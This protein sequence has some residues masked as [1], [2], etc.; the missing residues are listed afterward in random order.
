MYDFFSKLYPVNSIVQV[1]KVLSELKCLKTFIH[2]FHLKIIIL[3]LICAIR[4][5]LFFDWSIAAVSIVKVKPIL[6]I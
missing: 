2:G 6:V 4:G 1:T 3:V 5:L